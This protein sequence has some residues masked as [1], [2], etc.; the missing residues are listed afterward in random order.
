MLNIAGP[1]FYSIDFVCKSYY[2]AIYLN[3]NINFNNI[4][5]FS[6]IRILVI[7][8][9]IEH[10]KQANTIYKKGRRKRTSQETKY[11]NFN[12]ENYITFRIT[13][14]SWNFLKVPFIDFGK[15]LYLLTSSLGFWA[16]FLFQINF[17]LFDAT[18]FSILMLALSVELLNSPTP[19][20]MCY[21]NDHIHSISDKI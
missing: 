1:Y 19:T 13:L 18:Y 10:F 12:N 8:T 2:H 4:Y 11:N 20:S 21:K 6:S 5:A 3:N 16:L 9:C 7:I 17:L 15:I 14:F